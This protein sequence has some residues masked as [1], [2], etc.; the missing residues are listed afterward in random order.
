VTYDQVFTQAPAQGIK[1]DW[2]KEGK[3]YK[4]GS[5]YS[6]YMDEHF[7]EY[8]A[9][10]GIPSEIVYDVQELYKWLKGEE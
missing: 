8:S 7:E 1:Y 6:H 9:E 5:D 10:D 2:Q 3:Y 4:F